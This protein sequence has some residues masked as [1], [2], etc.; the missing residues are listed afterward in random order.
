MQSTK[1]LVQRC[2]AVADLLLVQE[3]VAWAANRMPLELCAR[4]VQRTLDEQAGL[5]PDRRHAR[6]VD[7]VLIDAIEAYLCTPIRTPPRAS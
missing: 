2:D 5:P 3:A 7:A 4:L 1:R 6:D